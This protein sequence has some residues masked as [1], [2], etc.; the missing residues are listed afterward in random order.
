ML[1]LIHA[2]QNPFEETGLRHVLLSLLLGAQW[3]HSLSPYL[4]S[5]VTNDEAGKMGRFGSRI[6][7]GLLTTVTS[8]A[9]PCLLQFQLTWVQG[10]LTIS[11]IFFM[12]HWKFFVIVHV[13][14][15]H[16]CWYTVS[17]WRHCLSLAPGAWWPSCRLPPECWNSRW[18]TTSPGISMGAGE[19]EL[20]A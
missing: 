1:Q 16:I 8:P 3:T 7:K 15:V 4:F 20:Q 14:V 5:S 6:T 18:T 11:I 17:P 13:C 2:P 9:E 19:S 10:A 12:T